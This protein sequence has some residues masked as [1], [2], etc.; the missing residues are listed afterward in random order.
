MFTRI[1]LED[2]VGV[3]VLRDYF[4]KLDDRKE[5]KGEDNV[6]GLLVASNRFTHYAR[7]EAKE[8][9]IWIITS[10]DPRFDIFTHD[11]VP[12]H[13]I[14][15]D[16][17]LNALLKK[18]NIQRRHLPKILANDPAVKAIGAKPGQVVKIY[19]NS[20]VAGESIAYRLVVRKT[21]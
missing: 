7:R 3:S 19:R 1:S 16:D 13:I 2:K 11:L 17:E 21:S 6:K 18:Y 12:E 4:K 10:K 20:N 15:P 5:E 9:N 14:C 8:N